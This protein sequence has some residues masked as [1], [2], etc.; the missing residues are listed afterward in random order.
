MITK[1]QKKML[2]LYQKRKWLQSGR[3]EEQLKLLLQ[4]NIT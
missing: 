3:Q 4:E 1:P 2:V